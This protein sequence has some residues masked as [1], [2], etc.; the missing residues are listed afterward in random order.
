MNREKC[1]AIY[2]L[3]L[4][5]TLDDDMRYSLDCWNHF[6]PEESS[7]YLTIEYRRNL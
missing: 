5:F 2:H 6:D 4:S 3:K 1:A 7:S